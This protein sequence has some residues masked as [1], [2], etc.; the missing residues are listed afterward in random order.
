M[1]SFLSCALFSLPIWLT[2]APRNVEEAEFNAILIGKF[3]GISA[4]QRRFATANIE[5]VL[6]KHYMNVDGTSLLF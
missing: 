3:V 4:A 1:L 2:R 6:S 5:S